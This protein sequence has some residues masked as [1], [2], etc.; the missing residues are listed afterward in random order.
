MPS[1]PCL[2]TIPC[3]ALSSDM[4]AGSTNSRRFN[5]S[6]RKSGIKLER[7]LV[8]ITLSPALRKAAAACNPMNPN[9]PVIRIIFSSN[10]CCRF[11]GSGILEIQHQFRTFAAGT[12]DHHGFVGLAFGVAEYGV[13]MIRNTLQYR[14]LTF[15]ADPQLARR[16]SRYTS[17]A[18]DLQN[19]LP[20]VDNNCFST[21]RQLYGEL[22]QLLNIFARLKVLQMA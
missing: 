16:C 13:V 19:R 10:Y 3:N 2:L 22:V 12:T 1:T 21:A 20:W 6:A 11:Y 14:C 8:T 17:Q 4:S 7:C 5:W 18:N 15:A 9:P